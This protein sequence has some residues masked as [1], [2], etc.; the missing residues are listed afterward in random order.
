MGAMIVQCFVWVLGGVLHARAEPCNTRFF[1]DRYH[2][3]W[4]LEVI[5]L[6]AHTLSL[7]RV[8]SRR[9]MC[10]I[11]LSEMMCQESD[12]LLHGLTP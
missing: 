11:E 1:P 2:S 10:G 9:R 4:Y 6:A 12:L 8:S 3:M 5:V 7:R